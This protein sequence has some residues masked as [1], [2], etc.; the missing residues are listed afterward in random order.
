MAESF[1]A[2]WLLEDIYKY[3]DPHQYGNRPG[4]ST[5][6][7]LVRLLHNI[8]ENCERPKSRPMSTQKRICKIILGKSSINYEDALK[9]CQLERLQIR[10]EKFL[11][12]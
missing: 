12:S 5:S 11:D 2:K 1:I 3:I 8:F 10:R 7:Y 9:R 6:H 4:L